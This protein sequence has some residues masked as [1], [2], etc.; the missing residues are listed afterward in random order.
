M[1]YSKKKIF[2]VSLIDDKSNEYKEYSPKENILGQYVIGEKD[3][4]FMIRM[5]ADPNKIKDKD[6]FG[7]KLFIDGEEVP[8]I[9]TFRRSGR[10]FGFKMGGGVYKQFKFGEPKFDEGDKGGNRNIGKIKIIFYNTI[11]HNTGRRTR[12]QNHIYRPKKETYLDANKKL[13]FKSLQVF[14]GETFDNGHTTRQRLKNQKEPKIMHVIDYQDD[15]DDVEFNYT[16]FYG[17]LSLGEISIN[18]INDLRFIPKSKLDYKVLG[19]AIYTILSQKGTEGSLML[20][21]LS[22][23]FSAICEQNLEAY[24][25]N[26]QYKTLVNLINSLYSDKFTLDERNE[27]IAIK[28]LNIVLAKDIRRNL[29]RD[30][31]LI[32]SDYLLSGVE[33]TI[34]KKRKEDRTHRKFYPEECNSN[35]MD[36]EVQCIDLTNDESYDREEN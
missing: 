24:Y 32:T 16:D 22:K 21:E 29:S 4:C 17:L 8:G 36:L 12:I 28:D 35:N 10:Y 19:N 6:V 33:K 13:C 1:V 20:S 14:E 5:I 2:Q 30:N 3:K 31:E 9:K 15:I 25:A 18:R 26:T 7:T 34:I 27:I 23:R 11:E